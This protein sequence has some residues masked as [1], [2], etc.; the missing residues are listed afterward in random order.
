MSDKAKEL[1]A[2]IEMSKALGVAVDPATAFC[3]ST[4]SAILTVTQVNQ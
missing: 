1:K 4:P 2:L 3:P